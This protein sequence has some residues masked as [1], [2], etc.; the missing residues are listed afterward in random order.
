MFNFQQPVVHVSVNLRKAALAAA[1]RV[2]KVRRE[3]CILTD[4]DKMSAGD[5][6]YYWYVLLGE[7][8]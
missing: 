5:G 8:R 6:L 4:L 7:E 1:K 3:Y 2:T